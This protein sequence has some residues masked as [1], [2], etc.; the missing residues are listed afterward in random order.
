MSPAF[1]NLHAEVSFKQVE[2][3]A[4]LNINRRI[5]RILGYVGVS[6]LLAE[7]EQNP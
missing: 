4:E 5:I 1:S 2:E 7:D 3:F 6:V